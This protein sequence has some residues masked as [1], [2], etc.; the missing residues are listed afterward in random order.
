MIIICGPTGSGK[1]ETALELA[2]KING[3]IISA[4][5]RQVYRHLAAGTSKPAGKWGKDGPR[6][7]YAV[8]GIPYH[9]VDFLEPDRVFSAGEFVRSAKKIIEEISKQGKISIVA[10][11]TGLYIRS[12][13]DGL[14]KLPQKDEKIREELRNLA[15]KHGKDYLHRKLREVDSAKADEIHPNNISRIIR[16]LEVYYITGTPVS[17][18]YGSEPRE[19]LNTE[20]AVFIGLAWQRNAL[21]SHIEKRVAGMLK[22]GMIDE[23]GKLLSLGYAGS[24]P[25]L[26]SLGYKF[27]IQYLDRKTDFENM[28]KNIALETKHYIKRQMTWF[29]REKRIN[30]LDIDA[31]DSGEKTADRIIALW[32]K[33]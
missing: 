31:S 2:R 13:T 1:T 25:A 21:Y 24:C 7:V 23:T 27:V 12:L 32:K 29:N 6:Q 5:S 16:A 4:D 18:L 30:W 28:K 3:E 10:G 14:T 8:R 33:S 9:L 17:K 20:K 15:E 22:E 11:G 26:Q 19:I